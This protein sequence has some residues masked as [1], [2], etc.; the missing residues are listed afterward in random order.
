MEGY[1]AKAKDEIVR[2]SSQLACCRRA[3]L[4]AL[5]HTGG[6]LVFSREGMRIAFPTLSDKLSSKVSTIVSGLIEGVNTKKDSTGFYLTGEKLLEALFALGI[7]TSEGE[8]TAVVEGVKPFIVSSDCCAVNYLRGAFLGCGSVTLKKGYHLEFPLSNTTL[9]RDV[10]NIFARFSITAKVVERK[11]KAVVYLKGGEA[12]SDGL[13]LLGATEAV[14]ELNNQLALRQ[15]RSDT[16]RR[17]NC[18]LGNISKTV[19]A[20]MRHVEDIKLIKRKIGIASLN[21][22]LQMVAEVR[23][24]YPEDS[25][26]ELS[27][28]VG[29]NKSTLKNRLVKIEEIANEI[30]EKEKTKR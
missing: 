26:S 8:E 4:S 9:A 30:R 5:V 3:F 14:L 13:A 28:R 7:F 16:N 18:E 6:S 21:E 25:L 19:N 24:D 15:F 2:L 17:N 22:K 12:V 23:L 29:L 10:V 20:S 11:E 27:A 1:S